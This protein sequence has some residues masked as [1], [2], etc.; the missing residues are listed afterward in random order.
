MD[1]PLPPRPS[2]RPLPERA[3][4]PTRPAESS[5][6]PLLD[7]NPAAAR[8]TRQEP[9]SRPDPRPTRLAL[10]AG[11]LA[12]A[13]ALAVAIMTPP[14]VSPASV[15]VPVARASDPGT[16]VVTVEQPVP[17]PIVKHVKRYITLNPGQ[18]PPPSALA[19]QLPAPTPRIVVVQA[20]RQVVVTTRQ[21]GRP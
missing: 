19:T 15:Q 14:A 18:T 2:N 3:P 17:T 6:D 20:P 7:R 10:A 8:A 4:V 16:A 11:G 21:S 5:G 12:T 13:S 9:R 1:R